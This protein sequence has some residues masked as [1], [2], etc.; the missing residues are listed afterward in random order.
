[1]GQKPLY[2]CES[3]GALYFASEIKA[4]LRIPG[5]ER[6]IDLEALSHY[7]SY[8]HV[9]HPL[10]IFQGVRMLPPAHLLLY[11]PG[12]P[13]IIRRYW[14]VDW[15][16]SA[17]TAGLSEEEIVDRLLD[18]LRRGVERRLMSDVAIGFFLGGGIEPG[19]PPPLAPPRPPR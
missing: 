16:G 8:K 9:P 6:R 14:D 15:S 1:M 19:P 10:S 13:V 18:L 11:R 12:S 4:L 5:F 17:E 3:G 7:L 2:Y